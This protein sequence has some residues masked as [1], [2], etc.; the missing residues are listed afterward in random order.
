MNHRVHLQP[1]TLS[2]ADGL[3]FDLPFWNFSTIDDLNIFEASKDIL[4][5]EDDASTT[6]LFKAMISKFS[7]NAR[8]KSVSSAEE[9]KKYLSYLIEQELDGPNVALIDY[10]LGEENGLM[11]CHLLDIYFPETKAV[12]ISALAPEEI[13]REIKKKRLGV[14]FIS[15]PIDQEKMIYILSANTQKE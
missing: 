9:A 4:I 15:K 12:V 6:K 5:V 14:E 7:E 3:K 11:V 13:K 8:V 1:G 10:N 2:V